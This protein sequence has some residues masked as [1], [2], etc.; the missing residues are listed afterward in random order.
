MQVDLDRDCVNNIAFSLADSCVASAVPFPLVEHEWI[1]WLLVATAAAF[2]AF[3]IPR[4]LY[5]SFRCPAI[6]CALA[7]ILAAKLIIGIAFA[8]LWLGLLIV[9]I[10]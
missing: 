7:F 8:S 1:F 5:L 3:A 10:R 4:I 6:T 9:A 2:V